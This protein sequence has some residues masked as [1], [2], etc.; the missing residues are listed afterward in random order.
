[1]RQQ[2]TSISSIII[3]IF[4]LQACAL[5][6]GIIPQRQA[7]QQSQQTRSSEVQ[8]QSA[9]KISPP[10]LTSPADLTSED[11][12]TLPEN[13]Q[14]TQQAATSPQTNNINA[15]HDLDP[16]PNI[17]EGPASQPTNQNAQVTQYSF[18]QNPRY[19]NCLEAIQNDGAAGRET[20]RQWV[21]D[22]G[23]LMAVH[24]L[25]VADLAAGFPKLAA[26]RLQ[27]LADSKSTGDILTRARLYAQSSE[28][29]LSADQT[30][31]AQTALDNAFQLAPEAG[32]LFL[33]SG[34]INVAKRRWQPTINA[35][36]KAEELGFTSSQG[37]TARGRAYKELTQFNDSANDVAKALTLDA[38]NL[39]ALVLRGEL[40]QTG[41]TINTRFKRVP[42]NTP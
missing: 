35:I 23:G 15:T 34:A 42:P 14:V 12:S 30:E 16:T 2:I 37:Y 31:E 40:A 28:I 18:Q 27:E 26:L 3:M 7:K 29:W 13:K 33:L 36:T 5:T 9:E 24:C 6:Q 17:V 41:I 20:A 39:D 11:E 25:S 1:M 32:E 21:H 22:G 10:D 38:F 19:K 8:N 4:S